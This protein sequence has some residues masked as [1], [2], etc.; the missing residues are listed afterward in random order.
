M[1]FM[2]NFCNNNFKTN[3]HL[4]RHQDT[5]KYCLEIQKRHLEKNTD[6]MCTAC[7]KVF[8]TKQN[9]QNHINICKENLKN[10]IKNLE[11]SKDVLQKSKDA[12]QKLYDESVKSKNQLIHD[13][14][15]KLEIYEKDHEFIKE[16]AKQPKNII[17]NKVLLLSPFAMSQKDINSIINHKFAKEYFL[18]DQ[19]G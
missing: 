17:N 5:V 12:L 4:K 19:K 2:C 14:Q 16:I 11:K 10:I 1:D 15:I 13:L 7:S 8:T 9:L 3:G 6:F 18:D